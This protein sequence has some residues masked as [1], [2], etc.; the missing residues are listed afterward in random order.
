MKMTITSKFS[1]IFLLFA[2]IGLHKAQSHNGKEFYQ[3]L[4]YNQALAKLETQVKEDSDNILSLTYGEDIYDDIKGAKCKDTSSQDPNA[5][6]PCKFP[7]LK[8]TNWDQ[9][10]TKIRSLP[11]VLFVAGV[12][13]DEV[14]GIYTLIYLIEYMK[15][16]SKF[17]RFRTLIN[18][19]MIIVVPFANPNGFS[20]KT[21]YELVQF[22]NAPSDNMKIDPA[23]DFGFNKENCMESTTARF[24]D[25]IYRNHL[26]ISTLVFNN[27]GTSA[28]GV[29]WLYSET[30]N[31]NDEI[32]YNQVGQYL[33]EIANANKQ[34]ENIKG[35]D[36]YH[37]TNLAQQYKKQNGAFEDWSYGASWK[38]NS[39]KGKMVKKCKPKTNYM[40]ADAE[41]HTLTNRSFTMS[42]SPS[43]KTVPEENTLGSVEDVNDL[44]V[45][46]LAKID[47]STTDGHVSRNIRVCLEFIKLVA[48]Y[49]IMS[50]LHL[51]TG[52][53]KL[54][55][56]Y[57]G[58]GCFNVSYTN[59]KWMFFDPKTNQNSTYESYWNDA[60]VRDSRQERNNNGKINYDGELVNPSNNFSTHFRIDETKPLN[61][62][63]I[64]TCD[65]E[66]TKKEPKS[67]LVRIRVKKD[68]GLTPSN[69]MGYF[70]PNYSFLNYDILR[71][72][73]TKMNYNDY[74]HT[75]QNFLNFISNKT[76]FFAQNNGTKIYLSFKEKNQNIKLVPQQ[77]N[78]ADFINSKL[79]FKLRDSSASSDFIFTK[80]CTITKPSNEI[81]CTMTDFNPLDINGKLLII[82]KENAEVFKS[83]VRPEKNETCLK[84][85][86]IKCVGTKLIGNGLVQ[87]NSDDPDEMKIQIMKLDDKDGVILIRGNFGFKYYNKYFAGDYVRLK[88]FDKEYKLRAFAPKSSKTSLVFKKTLKIPNYE[89][90]ILGKPVQIQAY[91]VLDIEKLANMKETRRRIK[92]RNNRVKK[93][94]LT[95]NN[96]KNFSYITEN[97]KRRRL[98]RLLNK[99]KIQRYQKELNVTPITMYITQFN[100][101]FKNNNMIYDN[102]LFSGLPENN[103]EEVQPP[104]NKIIEPQM[105]YSIWK[106][107]LTCVIIS[108]LVIGFAY[109]Y[110]NSKLK[111]MFMMK[112]VESGQKGEHD[113]ENRESA[114][115]DYKAT[116]EKVNL[117]HIHVYNEQSFKPSQEDTQVCDNDIKSQK[118]D[119]STDNL[120]DLDSGPFNSQ[121]KLKE[122]LI[123]DERAESEEINLG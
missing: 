115:K 104:A 10:T 25:Q 100:S 111:S 32:A 67:N 53:D 46:N 60:T 11:Q 93:R 73:P 6:T 89:K 20:N 105:S 122:N 35:M 86:A 51:D 58:G 112:R 54:A 12:H 55:L 87:V 61:I 44:S 56:K 103:N 82:K 113:I 98:N 47:G 71:L 72:Q 65:W 68:N 114:F 78:E 4:D 31:L 16:K 49:F 26:I 59:V 1:V 119:T 79:M 37:Y 3:P 118:A 108:L 13:G 75:E 84:K 70:L 69:N 91:H 106:V 19:R 116:F 101:I 2:F 97:V 121:R 50:E 14:I 117:K 62:R 29:P 40:L 5:T 90:F 33:T 63:L 23:Y 43:V 57:K 18:N 48:P 123:A 9:N 34:I 42:I 99:I 17:E 107:I 77:I 92:S 66:W 39:D 80:S 95:I 110:L 41:Y 94:R 52:T 64:L 109:F 8:I 102:T 28:V 24:L 45:D 15:L 83:V 120:T 74:D 30:A 7:I 22:G 21:S 36:K 85:N 88:I 76:K 81:G 38:I 96:Y 27:H